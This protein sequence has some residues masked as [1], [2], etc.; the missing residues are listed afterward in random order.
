MTNDWLTQFFSSSRLGIN[1]TAKRSTYFRATI[2]AKI[3]CFCG[4]ANEKQGSKHT[5]FREWR[6]VDLLAGVK[7]C[8]IWF[9]H[10]KHLPV[11]RHHHGPTRR[12][13]REIRSITFSGHH[14][15]VAAAVVTAVLIAC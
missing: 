3:L 7:E 6:R 13:R 2:K 14:P 4:G 1:T 8:R 15:R 12:R 5:N 11:S 10:H 9:T